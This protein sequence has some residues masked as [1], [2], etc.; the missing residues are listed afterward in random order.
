M[1][2]EPCMGDEANYHQ[3]ILVS[4]H[5]QKLYEIPQIKRDD[6]VCVLMIEANL[7]QVQITSITSHTTKELKHTGIRLLIM[8]HIIDKNSKHPQV[9]YGI[10]TTK[11]S[12]NQWVENIH[13]LLRQNKIFYHEHFLSI[14]NTILEDSVYDRNTI[15]KEFHEQLKRFAPLIKEPKDG[16]GVVRVELTGKHGPGMRDDLIAAAGILAYHPIKFYSNPREC[17][18]SPAHAA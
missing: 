2:S 15:R 1:E 12:K 11:E 5:I 10:R 18:I 9:L 6:P 8:R 13:M 4:T 3:N 16:M 17:G 7:S 14:G